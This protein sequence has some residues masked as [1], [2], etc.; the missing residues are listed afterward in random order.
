MMKTSNNPK[1]TLY[2]L[3]FAGGH[4][5]SYRDFQANVAENI[6][7]KPLELPGR[8]KRIREPLLTNLEA[9]ADDVFQQVISDFNGQLYAIYGHSMGATLGYLLT[10]RLVN[11]GKPAPLHL[12]VSGRKA[13]SVVN[14]EPPKHQRPKQAF[15]N[16]INE[17]GGLPPELLEDTEVMDF[18]EPIL[19]ADFQAIETYIYQPSSPFDIPISILHGLADKEVAYQDLLPWQQESRQPIAIKTFAGGHFFIFEHLFQL[20]QLFSRTLES[21]L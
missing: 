8:S 10:K 19:R 7:I 2:C 13:P 1:I 9:M 20:G 5:L 12:F 4:T 11:A 3:P 21:K 17:L 14:D 6:L 18:L 15:L 16:H